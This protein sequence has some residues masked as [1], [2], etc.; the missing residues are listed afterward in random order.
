MESAGDSRSEMSLAVLGVRAA[1]LSRSEEYCRSAATYLGRLLL[2]AQSADDDVKEASDVLVYPPPDLSVRCLHAIGN[3]LQEVGPGRPE[4]LARL[5]VE[6]WHSEE[7]RFGIA[8]ILGKVGPIAACA[9]EVLEQAVV[10]YSESASPA[11]AGA[12]FR[13]GPK[14]L[15]VFL[16]LLK[17][18][19]DGAW[20]VFFAHPEWI[21][22]EVEKQESLRKDAITLF[23]SWLL[24]E[25]S[26][27]EKRRICAQALSKIRDDDVR[28]VFMKSLYREFG[29]VDSILGCLIR[30][31]KEMGPAAI[32]ALTIVLDNAPEQMADERRRAVYVLGEMGPRSEQAIPALTRAADDPNLCD[33]VEWAIDRIRNP[34]PP[35]LREVGLSWSLY[36]RLRDYA[37][38]RGIPESDAVCEILDQHLPPS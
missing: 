18:D 33:A 28:S 16:E 36:H 29:A 9:V 2:T 25:T 22:E 21:G 12:L 27:A 10:D 14:G 23:Q 35:M 38:W 17:N 19:A 37:V 31:F 13:I 7:M 1:Y 3:G 11:A 20:S 26:P 6:S 5:L 8:E 34:Y 15:A 30:V 24:D 4:M 32:P